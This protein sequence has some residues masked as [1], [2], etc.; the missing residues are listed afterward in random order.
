MK[1]I[2]TLLLSCL[3]VPWAV[4]ED[5][6][7][8]LNSVVKE[9]LAANPML[10]ASAAKWAAMKER[11][12]QARAW[13]DPMVGVDFER[14]G[15]TRLN[16]FSDSEWMV[17]QSLPF[18]GKNMSRG[19]TAEAEARAAFEELRK[20]RLEVTAKTKSAY[21]RLSNAHSQLA[22]N[23][24][25]RVLLDDV[26][27]LG[28]S[29]LSVGTGSQSDVLAMEMDIQRLEVDRIGLEQI[30]S[31]QQTALNVL[32]NRPA[33]SPLGKPADLSFRAMP[34][35][36]SLES[37]LIA[38]RP[39]IAQAE[40]R[41]K[42]EEARLQLARREW[43]PDP[44]VRVEARHFKGSGDGFTEYDTG[45]FFSVPW[46]N[47][48]KYSAGIRE[49]QQMV[50]SMKREVEAERTTSLG[51][52]RDQLRKITAYRRQYELSRD[53]L[54]PLA[55]RSNETLRINYETNTATYIELLTVQRML[56][57]AES[58]ASTQL[59]DY[60]SAVA[61]LE[62]IVG[63][64]ALEPVKREAQKSRRKQQ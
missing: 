60:L 61:E 24:Q 13:D 1:P 40:Q 45:I 17:S 52:L 15:T 57:D 37:R 63:G 2:I 36:A 29:R 38:N 42:A 26:L 11:V 12:P 64:D 20:I 39:Q 5:P 31:E 51:A 49:A 27:K 19:R 23:A 41:L 21:Y 58:A 10:K 18:S 59:T 46:V 33:G 48:R 9:A 25:N 8:T 56:R 47:A 50:E 35:S 32:M 44:Q 16:T 4:A 54:V 22:I 14:M 53:K 55:R 30:L 28:N 7:L 62:A 3:F 34:E 43:I 6:E